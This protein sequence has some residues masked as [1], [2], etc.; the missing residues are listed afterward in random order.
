MFTRALLNSRPRKRRH[1]TPAASTEK[2]RKISAVNRRS[3]PCLTCLPSSSNKVAQELQ[4]EAQQEQYHAELAIY[5]VSGPVNNVGDTDAG[6]SAERL[7]RREW[8]QR[9]ESLPLHRLYHLK[10]PQISRRLAQARY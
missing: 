2:P 4:R 7:E 6:V 5:P 1:V 10:R 9:F 8:D 3:G